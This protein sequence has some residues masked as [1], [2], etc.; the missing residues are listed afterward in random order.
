MLADFLPLLSEAGVAWMK[1]LAFSI[2]EA[3]AIGALAYSLTGEKFVW[4]KLLVPAL[5]TGLAMGTIVTVFEEDRLPY[6]I[7]VLLYVAIFSVLYCACRLTLFWRV[8]T[9]VAF[10]T[11]IYLLL[12]FFNMGVRYFC[13]V[14]FEKYRESFSAKCFC[15][16]PQF[17]AAGLLA[18][19]FFR[20]K[21]NLFVTKGKEV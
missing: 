12:E 10:A 7:H 13:H 14:D 15:F 6:L 5:I 3:L 16:L 1:W 9:S 21:I 20:R 2:P 17:F 8:L 18:Y 19:V 4:W 11:S